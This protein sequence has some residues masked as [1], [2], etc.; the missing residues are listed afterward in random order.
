MRN[1]IQLFAAILLASA[2]AGAEDGGSQLQSILDRHAPSIVTV[3]AVLKFDVSTGG[4]AQSQE[5]RMESQGVVVDASG[6]IM[7]SS[8]LFSSED[9]KEGLK[10]RG[11]NADVKVTPSDIKIVFEGEDKECEAFLAATDGKLGVAYLQVVDLGDK[12]LAA[13]PSEGAKL[14]VGD[15]IA[16][17]SRLKKG[18]DYAPY[19]ETATVAGQI[20]KPRKA[21]LLDHDPGAMGLPAFNMAGEFAG[22]V[23]RVDA[24]TDED[25]EAANAMRMIRMLLGRGNRAP[26]PTFLV[27]PD[28]IRGSVDL[29]KKEAERLAVERANEKK[30]PPKEDPK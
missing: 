29:A 27:G 15:K 19:V 22:V 26:S 8:A 2:V 4:Q 25:A 1:R 13:L 14:A 12:K 3:K 23:V 30:E 28:A 24:A 6:L 20:T 21:V 10:L 5:S 9:L 16:F 17:V 18:Y 7:V 11:G